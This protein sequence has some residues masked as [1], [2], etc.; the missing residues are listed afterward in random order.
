MVINPKICKFFNHT[1]CGSGSA[2]VFLH[3]NQEYY[4]YVVTCP[5]KNKFRIVCAANA[6]GC[7]D[8][9][10]KCGYLHCDQDVRSC[11][12]NSIISDKLKYYRDMS[13]SCKDAYHEV[14][15][16][17]ALV[18]RENALVKRENEYLRKQCD[19]WRQTDQQDRHPLIV[20]K[21]YIDVKKD[22]MDF[23]NNLHP[24]K[25]H[26]DDSQY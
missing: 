12:K 23:L 3:L 17:N 15:R 24:N 18:K 13:E 21:R 16:E 11:R 19:V 20:T 26:K 10:D 22:A 25:R 6:I 7:C 4:N 9:Y 5:D 14:K 8:Y 2:C 1:T